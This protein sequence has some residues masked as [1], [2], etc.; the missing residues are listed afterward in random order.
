[1]ALAVVALALPSPRVVAGCMLMTIDAPY[2]CC[3]GWALVLG[4]QA[5]V[6]GSRWAW[7]A[8]GAVVGLGILAKYTMILWIASAG[9]FLLTTPAL[10]RLLFRPGFWIMTSV[11]GVTCLPILVW[12]VRHDWV[13][14]RHVSGQAGLEGREGILWLGPLEY[15]GVQFLLLLGFWFV[16]W[17][18]AMLA[19]RPWQESELGRRYLWWMSAPMFSCFLLFCFKT[20][21]EP[22]CPITDY[23]SWWV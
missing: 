22:N 1:L 16:A 5:F 12:N 7:P 17:A 8:L 14:L 4:Y 6:R 10:R 9:L 18:A 19:H 23:L 11:A 13:S 15:V 21:E 2:A 3:W 20:H